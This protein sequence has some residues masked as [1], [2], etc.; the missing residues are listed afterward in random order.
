MIVNSGEIEV[1]ISVEEKPKDESADT[2]TDTESDQKIQDFDREAQSILK[3]DR[4]YFNDDLVF[5]IIT[6]VLSVGVAISSGYHSN[7]FASGKFFISY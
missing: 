5:L 6:H 2:E 3:T 7:H 4:I 1:N